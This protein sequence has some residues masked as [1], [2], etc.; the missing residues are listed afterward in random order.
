MKL[1]ALDVGSGMTKA[2]TEEDRYA[3]PSI[4][5]KS[6]GIDFELVGMEAS[7]KIVINNEVWLTGATANAHLQK[8]QLLSATKS[9]WNKSK[10]HL[11]MFYSVLAKIF[12]EGYEGNIRLVSGLPIR[13]FTKDAD[14][15]RNS[16]VGVHEFKTDKGQYKITISTE[17][18]LIV[19]QVLGLHF[20]NY[21]RNPKLNL[22][23]SRVGYID[24]GTYSLGWAAVDEGVYQKVIS[25]GADVGLSKLSKS[26]EEFLKN[27]FDWEPDMPF[28]VLNAM[29]KGKMSIY[30][31][32]EMIEVDLVQEAQPSVNQVYSDKLEEISKQWKGAR[33]RQV[34][35]GSGGGKYIIDLVRRYFPH[36]VLLNEDKPRTKSKPK[37]SANAD[38]KGATLFDV[39]EGFLTYG[40][41]TV[42]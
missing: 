11:I 7:E 26:L 9:T 39:V 5:G 28:Q 42:R 2:M 27:K 34:F 14:S 23:E 32:G 13:V 1:I 21:V 36:A 30:D 3:S 6:Q 10:G 31:N 4:V 33:S 38:T 12:P 17:D 41:S 29:T 18:C 15:Y 25:D 24:P 22:N 16:L 35:V 8:D 40:K 37:P 20:V 19:P